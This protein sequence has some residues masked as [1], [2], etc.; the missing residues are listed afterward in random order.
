MQGTGLALRLS[1]AVA[2]AVLAALYVLLRG[3]KAALAAAFILALGAFAAVVLY[4]YVDI[5]AVGPH[6]AMYEPV[7][8]EKSLGAV[9]DAVGAMLAGLG[10]A[11]ADRA[12][13]RPAP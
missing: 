1:T 12:G 4:R 13:S 7:W 5:S 9:A 11:G 10:F 2:A 3:S 8:F 6:S